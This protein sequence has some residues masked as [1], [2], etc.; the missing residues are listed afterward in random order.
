MSVSLQEMYDLLSEVLYSY[1]EEL[2]Q[3]YQL[4]PESN[5]FHVNTEIKTYDERISR[6]KQCSSLIR[7]TEILP[8]Q[9]RLQPDGP[10]IPF[11]SYRIRMELNF[12]H[13]ILEIEQ[14]NVYGD[15]LDFARFPINHSVVMTNPAFYFR[16]W[17]RMDFVLQYTEERFDEEFLKPMMEIW[18][19]E[20]RNILGTS[21]HDSSKTLQNPLLGI[22]LDQ[23]RQME[24]H[25][26]TKVD[27]PRQEYMY[28]AT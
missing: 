14:R 25:D 2:A 4:D 1:Y 8:N 12:V 15:V 16:E 22:P 21:I 17:L 28:R 23:W 27:V 13:N 3:E 11:F 10:S 20:K 6:S 5:F 18:E 19:T 7:E 26:I 24:L 9:Y